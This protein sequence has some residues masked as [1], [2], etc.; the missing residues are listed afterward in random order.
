MASRANREAFRA[1]ARLSLPTC[2][3]RRSSGELCVHMSAWNTSFVVILAKHLE[4]QL[5][6]GVR[7]NGSD[8]LLG[9]HHELVRCVRTLVIVVINRIVNTY[10][11]KTPVQNISLL[12][13]TL[14]ALSRIPSN[15][16]GKPQLKIVR[17]FESRSSWISPELVETGSA[18][19]GRKSRGGL[20]REHEQRDAITT[21][22]G[23]LH[24]L[25]TGGGGG[26][27]S[28]RGN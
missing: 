6:R 23:G 5:W 1:R 7:A 13:T 14:S 22:L 26:E 20:L 16:S 19:H 9:S 15:A 17:E 8:V 21:K 24:D 28:E 27:A 18:S 25:A 3:R 10:V 12:L 4:L 2:T 11:T